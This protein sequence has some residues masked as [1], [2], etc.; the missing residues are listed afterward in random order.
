[1]PKAQTTLNDFDI[2]G[3]EKRI[4]QLIANTSKEVKDEVGNLR[5]EMKEEMK[6]LKAEFKEDI[7]NLTTKFESDL[8]DTK[9]ELQKKI[10]ELQ[11]NLDRSEYHVRKYNLIFHGLKGKR[12]EEKKALETF[13]KDKLDM[14]E[15]PPTVNIHVVGDKGGII[16]RFSTWEGRQEVFTRANK[17]RGT[18]FGIQ[19]DLPKNL[20]AKKKQL[21]TERKRLIN[22]GKQARVIERGAD[23][24]LQKRDRSNDKWEKVEG[25]EV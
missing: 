20:V 11:Q 22:S 17:L 14:A 4:T 12:G 19:T 24:I 21:L 1:M 2:Q 25:F 6:I 13:C 5:K 18:D 9:E 23:V 7:T 8:E 15:L 10:D 3:M 16:A